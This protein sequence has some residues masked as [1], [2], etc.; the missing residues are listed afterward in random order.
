MI[1]YISLSTGD[2]RFPIRENMKRGEKVHQR[3]LKSTSFRRGVREKKYISRSIVA[4]RGERRNNK[5]SSGFYKLP[6]LH[7]GFNS[8]G[9]NSSRVDDS[10]EC[11][12]SRSLEK[13][14]IRDS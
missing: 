12:S 7:I 2:E 3:E 9:T 8:T 14:H 11:R 5:A 4:N 10:P 6:E 1:K 13:T